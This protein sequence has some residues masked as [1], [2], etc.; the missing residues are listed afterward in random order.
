MVVAVLR[1]VNY[2]DLSVFFAGTVRAARGKGD[3]SRGKI[4][5]GWN[6]RRPGV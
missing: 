6:T 4:T 3:A 5:S 1:I 2:S